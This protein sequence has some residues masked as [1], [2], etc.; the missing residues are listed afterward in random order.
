MKKLS[1]ISLSVLWVLMV[2]CGGSSSSTSSSTAGQ[3]WSL[4]FEDTMHPQTI[5]VYIAPITTGS[6]W[7]VTSDSPLLWM[8]DTSGNKCY[9]LLV[10]G[11]SYHDSPG[12]RFDCVN[13]HGS[14]CGMQTVGSCSFTINGNFPNANAVA[15]GSYTLSTTSPLGTITGT[16]SITGYRIQN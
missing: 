10:G 4:T 1:L 9:N 15:K 5:K 12:D 8:Y 6:T 11:N 14:G 16:Q 13:L 7:G 3:Y 2:S